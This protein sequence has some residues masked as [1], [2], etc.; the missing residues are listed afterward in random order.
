[1][2]LPNLSMRKDIEPDSECRIKYFYF[3]PQRGYTLNGLKEILR[4]MT[5]ASKSTPS[6][7]AW[8]T[9]TVSTSP[10]RTSL[11]FSLILTPFSSRT[12]PQSLYRCTIRI[13][14]TSRLG[15]TLSLLG[16]FPLLGL[17]LFFLLL[18]LFLFRPSSCASFGH[19]T[20]CGRCC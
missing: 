4:L 6:S 7:R 8:S 18:F 16:L 10:T 20:C 15:D 9:T 14:N 12:G 19:S 2:V 1:M 17:F 3:R 5:S 13:S 11:T